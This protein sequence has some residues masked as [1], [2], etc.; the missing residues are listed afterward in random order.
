MIE[1]RDLRYW[2]FIRSIKVVHSGL[3][4][5]TIVQR[6]KKIPNKKNKILKMSQRDR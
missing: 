5:N 6:V 3:D 2:F 1:E 4:E